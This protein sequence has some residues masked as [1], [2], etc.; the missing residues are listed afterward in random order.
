MKMTEFT[1]QALAERMIHAQH[2]SVIAENYLN[3]DLHDRPQQDLQGA[4]R[5]IARYKRKYP[6]CEDFRILIVTK[7]TTVISVVVT[8]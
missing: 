4:R 8:R 6:T 3:I 7:Q 5:A 2:W 1:E